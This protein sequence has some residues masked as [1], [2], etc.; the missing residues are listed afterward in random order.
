MSKIT[1]N[2]RKKRAFGDYFGS[3]AREKHADG[4]GKTAHSPNSFGKDVCAEKVRI[5]R[6][7]L[8]GMRGKTAHLCAEKV[9]IPRIITGGMRGKTAR[10]CAEKVRIGRII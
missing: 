1:L 5:G 8:G 6:I 4:R 9:R 7:I 3:D 2:A 10:V